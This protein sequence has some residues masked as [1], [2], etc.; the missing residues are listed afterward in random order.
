M[1]SAVVESLTGVPTEASCFLIPVG[2]VLYTVVG[3]LKATL[4]SDYTHGLATLIIIFIFAFSAYATNSQLG[5]PGS[6]WDTLTAVAQTRPVPGNKD[7]SYLTMQSREGIIFFVINII[8]NFGTVF[9]DNGYF[10]KS[11]AASPVDCLPGYIFGGLSWFAIPWLCATTMGLVAVALEANPVFPTYPNRIPDLEVTAG[12]VLPYAA[13]ALLGTSGAIA[14]LVL[15]FFAVTSAYSSEL[16]SVSSI[17]TYDV[18]TTYI[19]RNAS[20]KQMIW[21]SHASCVVSFLSH[22]SGSI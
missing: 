2:V 13:R 12:L 17:W 14:T 10:N 8:G 11:V 7:G 9:L 15:I 22:I 16:I 4:I 18:Y 19:N 21:M 20:S 6:V 5:S 3:G 1:G